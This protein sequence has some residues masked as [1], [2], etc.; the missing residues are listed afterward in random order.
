LRGIVSRRL[1]CASRDSIKFKN[2]NAPAVKR[3]AEVG[4]GPAALK[5]S[6]R[7]TMDYARLTVSELANGISKTEMAIRRCRES[8]RS[9]EPKTVGLQA[10]VEATRKR[11]PKFE[12]DLKALANAY[13]KRTKRKP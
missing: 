3:E 13:T 11:L 5:K 2:P 7:P 1:A 9:G 6:R 4:P 8:R 10:A 12:E